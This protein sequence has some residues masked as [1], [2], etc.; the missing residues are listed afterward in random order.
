MQW[1]RAWAVATLLWAC[2]CTPALDWR[3]VRPEGSGALVLFPCKPV[4]LVRN[5]PLGGVSVPMT[6]HACRAG[7]AVYG[8]GFAEAGDPARVTPAL[9]ELR[10][11]ALANLGARSAEALPLA[12]QGSTPNARA[13]AWRFDGLRPDGKAV[14]ESV[15]LFAH[16]TRVYQA[17]VLGAGADAETVRTFFDGLRVTR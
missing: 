9:H 4:G 1:R 12:V 3:E 7:D 11:A 2:A 14:R 17:S 13:G 16:G 10:E 8:F 6:I 5:V 15:A